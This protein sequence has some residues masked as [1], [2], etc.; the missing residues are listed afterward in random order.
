MQEA[1]EGLPGVLELTVT[2]EDDRFDI[3]FDPALVTAERLCEKVRELGYAPQRLAPGEAP[4]AAAV[5]RIDPATLP[6]RL[7]RRFEEAR[8]SGKPLLLD[9]SGPG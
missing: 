8:M 9:F 7:R 1:L 3:R 5:E 6:D 4:A 2:L